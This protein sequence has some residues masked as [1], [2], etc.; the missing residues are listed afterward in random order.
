[1]QI[2]TPFAYY[3]RVWNEGTVYRSHPGLDILCFRAA[4][5]LTSN[6]IN[7]TC[8]AGL[9]RAVMCSPTCVLDEMLAFQFLYISGGILCTFTIYHKYFIMIH[10]RVCR[11]S[12]LV[13]MVEIADVFEE[14]DF[15]LRVK[16]KFSFVPYKIKTGEY[17]SVMYN[18]NAYR[19]LSFNNVS[20]SLRFTV[21]RHSRIS[22][23]RGRI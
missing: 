8:H 3:F 2:N 22:N 9:L 20:T 4:F 5:I 1:M 7:V 18:I 16:R 23:I 10:S 12:H 13:E 11:V 6:F 14:L 17:S 19:T 21:L 15:L